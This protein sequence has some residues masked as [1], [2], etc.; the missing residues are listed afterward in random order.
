[1]SALGGCGHLLVADMAGN[2]VQRA[3]AQDIHRHL[4]FDSTRRATSAR[5]PGLESVIH[6]CAKCSMSLFSKGNYDP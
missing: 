3:R 6:L 5:G 2:A 1:M 4:R